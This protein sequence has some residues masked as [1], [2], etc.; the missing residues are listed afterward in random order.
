MNLTLTTPALLFPAI[1]LLLLAYTNRF[2]A[3]S[4]TI[5]Q[6]YDRHR[7][8]PDA[9]LIRQISNLRRRVELIRWMQTLG[10]ASI[11]VTTL[12]MFLLFMGWPA[13]G[14]WS[15]VIGLVLMCGSLALSLVE[16]SISGN[17]LEILLA[18]LEH[19]GERPPRT[20]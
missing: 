2:L 19:T 15:F 18:D 7:N 10:T 9:G 13:A 20:R 14:T 3:L 4:A 17:A 11:L 16:L 1:S 6:L 8:A 12:S 5:R